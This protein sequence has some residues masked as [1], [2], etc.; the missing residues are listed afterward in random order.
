VTTR[1][2]ANAVV[3]RK[4]LPDHNRR[5]TKPPGSPTDAHRPLG[6]RQNVAAILSIQESRLVGN[7][8]TVRF[9]NRLY[10]LHKPA[11]PGL[12]LGRVV[13]EQRL[14]GSLAIRF[15]ERYLAYTDL[16]PPPPKPGSLSHRR[17]LKGSDE[18]QASAEPRPSTVTL[19]NDCSGRT[20]AELD[21][22]VSTTTST[23]GAPYRPPTT[24]PWR[25]K[26]LGPTP[27]S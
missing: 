27:T 25:R 10:Q 11:L 18:H 4:L 16:G 21:R 3:D 26:F 6:P 19:T 8:Y 7:D 15:G 13:M 1:A 24:H 23:P 9:H 22:V 2:E 20:S 14:D 12:R 5:F 17:Q